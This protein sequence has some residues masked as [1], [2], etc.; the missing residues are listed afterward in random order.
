MNRRDLLRTS[1][2]ASAATLLPR[3]VFAEQFHPTGP[4]NLGTTNYIR[5][6]MTSYTFRKLKRTELIAALKSL[7]LSTVN[8]KDALDHMPQFVAKT[9]DI[10]YEGI[11]AAVADYIAADIKVTAVGTVYFRKPEE[12]RDVDRPKGGTMLRYALVF[13]VVALIA[14]AFGFLGIAAAAVSVARLLFYVFLIL[15]LISLA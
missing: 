15:F 1:A 5:L 13:F 4:V 10:D 11:K 9:T 2:L 12:F 8:C 6:G 14:A 3:S 7:H